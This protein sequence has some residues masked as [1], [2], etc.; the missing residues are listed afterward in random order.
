[1]A[2]GVGARFWPK[3]RQS[4]PK[5]FLDIFGT[6]KS[7]L[8]MTFERFTPKV[9]SENFLV[10][11]NR[12]YKDLVLEQLPEI[13]PAQV[14]CEPIGKNTAPCICYAAYYLQKINPKAKMIVTP[15]DHLV[16]KEDK[17]HEILDNALSFIDKE[18]ILMTIGITPSRPETG[19][20]YI[21]TS[22]S[23]TISKVKCFTEKPN[24]ELAE[25]FIQSGEFFWNSG[26]FIWKVRDII[27]AI[28]KFLPEHHALFAKITDAYG[29]ERE[30]EAIK[31][32]F[33]ECR[34]ISIDYGVME[35][36]E[37]VYVHIGEFGWSDVGT[38]GSLYQHSRKDKCANAIP[39]HGCYLYDT[40]S[41]IISIPNGKIAVINGLKDYI[42]VDTDDA[43]LICPRSEEQNIK[44]YIDE[45]KFND[46]DKHI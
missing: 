11:T 22:D 30:E 3:S 44:K 2:G 26:I 24:L 21:Q 28:E 1:M 36:A 25:A 9:N 40:K 7:F 39:E 19:Y 41:S 18:N 27:N 13:S 35:K 42:V 29:T 32:V 15:S 34:P 17:F 10:V 16:L 46:G 37:N 43:L 6:G 38:W 33:A 12:K 5:Q 8:R 14:L 4:M 45:V 31:E 20:G 23:D